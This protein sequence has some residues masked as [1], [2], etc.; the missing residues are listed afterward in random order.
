MYTLFSADAGYLL[1]QLPSGIAIQKIGAKLTLTINM[2]GTAL[3]G[4]LVPSM[5]GSR[6]H[7][8]GKAFICL[9]I[10]GM[11]Q[12]SLIPAHQTMKKARPR[13]E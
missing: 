12:G 11:F 1:T 6:H 13:V 10:M 2:L 5:L 7:P 4:F 3:M 9:T 8:L